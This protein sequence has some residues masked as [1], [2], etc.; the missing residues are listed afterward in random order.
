MKKVYEEQSMQDLLVPHGK[1]FTSCVLTTK[2]FACTPLVLV[3]QFPRFERLLKLLWIHWS[4]VS[5][6]KGLVWRP[7]TKHNTLCIMV[8]KGLEK[9]SMHLEKNLDQGVHVLDSRF[10]QTDQSVETA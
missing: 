8:A 3:N 4:S 10:Q 9:P 6:L 7:R 1:L 2:G 5:D